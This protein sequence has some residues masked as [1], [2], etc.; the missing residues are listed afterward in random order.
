MDYGIQSAAPMSSVNEAGLVARESHRIEAQ[1]VMAKKFPRD[2]IR[3]EQ[4][5]LKACQRTALAE[6]AEY[7]FPRGNETVKGPSIRLAE[8]IAQNWGNLEF[9]IRE[10]EQRPG[11]STME[12]YAWDIENNVY[13]SQSFEAAH[14]RDLKGGKRQ[15]VD[16]A[17]DIYEV[18]ANMGARRMRA[19]ILQLIPG[20]IVDKA[21]DECRKT[22]K[23]DIGKDATKIVKL[24]RKAVDAFSK[25]GITQA[26]MEEKCGRPMDQWDAE[27]LTEFSSISVSLRD[28]I[29]KPADFFEKAAD[30]QRISIAQVDEL[31]RA[32]KGKADQ[33]A[34]M[35]VVLDAGFNTFNEVTV[36]AFKGIMDAIAALK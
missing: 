7:E 35:K 13:R 26:M 23:G 25:H 27:I 18:T 28:G 12:A 1:V 20:D 17:R 21:V 32:I 9:G 2:E 24:A 11:S 6:E 30:T 31:G 3:A 16:S 4:R 19:C 15:A 34:C 36:S 10:L 5:I 14:V 22:L 29:A 33:D 8:V